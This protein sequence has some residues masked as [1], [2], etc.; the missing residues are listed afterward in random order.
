MTGWW[1]LAVACGAAGT[2]ARIVG[3]RALEARVPGGVPAATSVVNIVGAAAMGVVAA[4]ASP[5]L[6][7]VLGAGLLGGFTTFSTWMVE[8][9]RTRRLRNAMALI[10]VPTV[11][12]ALA[13]LAGRA[14]G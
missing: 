5:A 3:T 6:A 10:V 13:Y 7:L 8:I 1:I 4:Q 12:G 11:V 14:I 9:D 2:G